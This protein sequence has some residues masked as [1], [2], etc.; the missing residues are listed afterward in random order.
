MNFRRDAGFL[1]IGLGLMLSSIDWVAVGRLLS[2][3]P[4]AKARTVC[5]FKADCGELYQGHVAEGCGRLAF[6]DSTHV[7]VW[8]ER[9]QKVTL[10]LTSCVFTLV[11]HR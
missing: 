4:K 5:I 6:S 2:T 3:T 1:L 9:G 7:E 10:P 8:N 11:G